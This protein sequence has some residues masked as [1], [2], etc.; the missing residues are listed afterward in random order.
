MRCVIVDYGSGN[1]RSVLRGLEHVATNHTVCLSDDPKTIAEADHLVLPGVGAFSHC[2]HS[3][4]SR[5]GVSEALYQQVIE[6][7]KP[8]LGICVGMQLLAS[9]GEEY[10]GCA[11][12][13]WIAGRVQ[14]FDPKA[15]QGLAIPRMGWGGL[16]P[17]QKHPLLADLSPSGMMYF[18]HSYVFRPE[19][20]DHILAH[21]EYGEN[22]CALV[23]YEN[24]VGTQFHPEKSQQMGLGLLNNFL[25]WMP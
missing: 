25:H 15:T 5:L 12:L 22:Y 9:Y 16:I 11:G 2:A 1:V 13:D 21:T 18:V 4:K 20:P 8:F 17:N 19:N 7:K 14:P 10:D 3:L 6:R 24:I 23:G